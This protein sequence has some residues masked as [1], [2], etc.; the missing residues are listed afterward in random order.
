MDLSTVI[1]GLDP[2]TVT[3]TRGAAPT[4][5]N[6]WYTPGAT[7]PVS[8]TGVIVPATNDEMAAMP[9]G[10]Q[11]KDGIR[12]LTTTELKTANEASKTPADLVSYG[13]R[14]YEVQKV[15]YWKN[16]AFWDALATLIT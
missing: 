16:G 10:L 1:L 9:E 7:T 11:E 3:V 4:E 8:V 13:G 14:T 5:A 15:A 6:G 2:E 12:L